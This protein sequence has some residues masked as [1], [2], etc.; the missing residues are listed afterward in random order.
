[1]R[2]TGQ[3]TGSDSAA[4]AVKTIRIMT[5]NVFAQADVEVVLL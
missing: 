5:G 2:V 1:M 3:P 4:D